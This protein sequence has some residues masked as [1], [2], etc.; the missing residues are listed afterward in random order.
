MK[1]IVSN[2]SIPKVPVILNLPYI[3]HL[4]TEI[5]GR[6]KNKTHILDLLT[7]LYPT[8][9]LLGS[10][11]NNA[12]KKIDQYEKINR[13]WYGGC[14]GLYDDNGNG[15]FYVPIR[16]G[17]IKGK[18]ITLFTGSGIVSKSNARKEWEETTLK[19]EH[20]LSYFKLIFK[21]R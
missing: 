9:A 6:L 11:Y 20:I 15:E 10:P 2:I 5:S 7:K 13:G 14:I 16:S 4:Y 1:K 8:P 3:Y 19:L 12:F 21:I 18:N 17:L